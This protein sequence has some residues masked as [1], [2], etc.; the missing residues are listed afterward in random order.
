MQKRQQ[1][2]QQHVHFQNIYRKLN[3]FW[4]FFHLFVMFSLLA[5]YSRSPQKWVLLLS[6]H[7]SV[8]ICIVCFVDFLKFSALFF[9]I[10]QL[11][12]PLLLLVVAHFIYLKYIYIHTYIQKYLRIDHFHRITPK[13]THFYCK[14]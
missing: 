9:I 10:I 1:Q 11:Q 4:C 8:C 6:I 12:L 3:V 14:F 2:Q 7:A 13:L 5:A